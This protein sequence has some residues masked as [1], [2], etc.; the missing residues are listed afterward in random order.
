M[1]RIRR[2]SIAL[3]VFYLSGAFITLDWNICRWAIFNEEMGR[4]AF[5]VCI[6]S[7]AVMS[8]YEFEL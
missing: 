1:V 3:L 4:A 2:F 7:F 6:A 5:L 8:K